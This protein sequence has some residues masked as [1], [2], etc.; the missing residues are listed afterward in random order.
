MQNIQL[1][2]ID[3]QNDFCDPNGALPVPGADAAARI[4]SLCGS[5]T[6]KV[7]GAANGNPALSLKRIRNY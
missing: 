1:L 6:S 3:P 7:T 4:V 5:I 2:L